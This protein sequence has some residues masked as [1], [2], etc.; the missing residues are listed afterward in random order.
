MGDHRAEIHIV[1][2]IHGKTYK[3]DWDWINYFD[4]RDGIDDRVVEFFADSWSD[5]YGR[6]QKQ[7]DK[8][9]KESERPII[10]KREKAELKRLKEK[11]ES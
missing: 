11:Y 8:A 5:A 9:R 6:F 3:G 2:K 4:N 10:E 1:F 7:L